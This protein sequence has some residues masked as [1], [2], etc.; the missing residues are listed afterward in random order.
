MSAATHNDVA[1]QLKK[2]TRRNE[3]A[4]PLFKSAR[5]NGAFE[6]PDEGTE[7]VVSDAPCMSDISVSVLGQALAGLRTKKKLI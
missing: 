6:A 2:I 7:L 5:S 3:C 4:N 1:E